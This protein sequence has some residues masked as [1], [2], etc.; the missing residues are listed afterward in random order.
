MPWQIYST[1]LPALVLAN[2][3][4]PGLICM[5]AAI[6]ERK[7]AIDAWHGL[8]RV[9]EI[10]PGSLVVHAMATILLACGSCLIVDEPQLKP[11]Q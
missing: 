9:S 3:I 6:E 1:G 10:F 7:F 2:I 5:H 8:P 11:K 4:D